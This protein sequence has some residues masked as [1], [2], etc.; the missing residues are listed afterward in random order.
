MKMTGR[1][2]SLPLDSFEI[3]RKDQGFVLGKSLKRPG[4][5]RTMEFENYIFS[6]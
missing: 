1:G 3:I 4:F 5:F 2:M 6:E